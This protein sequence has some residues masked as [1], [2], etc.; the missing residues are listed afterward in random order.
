MEVELLLSPGV[1]GRLMHHLPIQQ[2]WAMSSHV[3][4][5]FLEASAI[6]ELA[7]RCD[8]VWSRLQAHEGDAS[9]TCLLVTQPSLYASGQCLVAGRQCLHVHSC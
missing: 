3:D 2:P 4:A 1:L 9:D 5:C 8:A 7:L 6:S